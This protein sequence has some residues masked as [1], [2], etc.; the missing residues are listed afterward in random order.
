MRLRVSCPR[1]FAGGG[2][3]A[4]PCFFARGRFRERGANEELCQRV[5]MAPAGAPAGGDNHRIDGRIRHAGKAPRRG[6]KQAGRGGSGGEYAGRGGNGGEYAGRGG[7]GGEYVG[8]GGSGGE[9]AG[10]NDAEGFPALL[11]GLVRLCGGGRRADGLLW[12]DERDRKAKSRHH[13]LHRGGNGG[14]DRE[15]A[16]CACEERKPDL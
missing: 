1:I 9:Y 3:K 13:H 15:P 12:S 10:S 8:R 14:T 6:G 7:N 4:D 5:S 16:V 2:A 11:G